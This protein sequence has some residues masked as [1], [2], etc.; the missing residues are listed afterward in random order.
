MRWRIN[1]VTVRVYGCGRRVCG[2]AGLARRL[3]GSEESEVIG[4][5]FNRV[6][7]NLFE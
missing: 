6:I 4:R 5:L 2:I 7:N 3:P 1:S